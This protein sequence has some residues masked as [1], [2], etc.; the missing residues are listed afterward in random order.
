MLRRCLLPC[1]DFGIPETSG[2]EVNSGDGEDFENGTEVQGLRETSPSP[3]VGKAPESRAEV[4]SR[5]WRVE[6]EIGL[7]SSSES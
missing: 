4:R 7:G 1:P 5:N 2:E 3:L 6:K